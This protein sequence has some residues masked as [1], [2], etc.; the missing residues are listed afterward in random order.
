MRLSLV[1]L[2]SLFPAVLGSQVPFTMST[3]Y[4]SNETFALKGGAGIFSPKSLIELVRPGAG[5]ANDVGDLV[6]VPISKYSFNDK[7]WVVYTRLRLAV[8]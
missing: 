6:F 3:P 7:E 1:L 8:T 5:V 2:L 4:I